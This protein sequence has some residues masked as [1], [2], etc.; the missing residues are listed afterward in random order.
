MAH[1]PAR[2][3]ELRN[4]GATLVLL[5]V[6]AS[7][8]AAL[9]AWNARQLSHAHALV[10]HTHEG[11]AELEGLPT[12]VARVESGPRGFV[13]AGDAR[14]LSP[15]GEDAEPASHLARLRQLIADNPQQA[16]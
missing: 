13:V 11:L 14:F 7:G 16:R 2:T 10:D 1:L 6:L 5:V 8:A 15:P 3:L 12:S 9:F 4:I